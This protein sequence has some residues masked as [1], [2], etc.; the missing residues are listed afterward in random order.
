MQANRRAV[1]ER[2]KYGETFAGTRNTELPAKLRAVLEDNRVSLHTCHSLGILSGTPQLSL[3]VSK[4]GCQ[5]C[6]SV[7]FCE[8]HHL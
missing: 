4:H 2:P 1:E 5:L 3:G 7:S 6:T 8:V